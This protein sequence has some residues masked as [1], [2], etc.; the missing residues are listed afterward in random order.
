MPVNLDCQ[1]DWIKRLL[2]KGLDH[3]GA[4]FFSRLIHRCLQLNVLLGI[5]A[6]LEVGP[7]GV[8]LEGIF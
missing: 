4:I 8:P 2:E 7:W 3:G 5:G 6:Q 1:L